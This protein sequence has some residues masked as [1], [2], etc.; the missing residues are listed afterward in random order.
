V[1]FFVVGESVRT[2]PDAPLILFL[3]NL[4][5]PSR[6]EPALGPLAE[7]LRHWKEHGYIIFP[8]AIEEKY[9]DKFIEDIRET[10]KCPQKY[11]WLI[12]SETR[13]NVPLS[14]LT[15]DDL[16]ERHLRF[17]DFHN[18]SLAGKRLALARPIVEFLEAVFREEVVAI[19]GYYP[20]SHRRK[21]HT[22]SV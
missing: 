10:M 11:P 3:L 5:Q 1:K 9:I 20:G 4:N 18:P 17:L 2:S 22:S 6:L 8:K 12:H 15:P 16:K 7:A 21:A 13:G 14:E 19:Q